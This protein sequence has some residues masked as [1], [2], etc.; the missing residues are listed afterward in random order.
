MMTCLYPMQEVNMEISHVEA[1]FFISEIA[2][3]FIEPA[4]LLFVFCYDEDY[5]AVD[6]ATFQMLL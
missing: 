6:L 5:V 3:L 4:L 2:A 1:S